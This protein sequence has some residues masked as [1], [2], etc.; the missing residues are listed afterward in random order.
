MKKIC[1]IGAG[2]WGTALAQ[3][4][5]NAGHD[6][7][8]WARETEVVESIKSKHENSLFLKD[9]RLNEM[10]KA[11]HNLNDTEDCDLFFLM[12]PAQHVRATIENFKT[13]LDEKPFVIGSK[14]IELET[15]SLLSDVVEELL[16]HA[17]FGFLSGPTFASEVA[18]GLPCAVTLA[19]NNQTVGKE[20]VEFIGSRT[21]RTYLTTDIIGVQIGG[22]VKN[23]IA[24]ACG[25][26]EGRKMGESARCALIT[27][28]LAEMAR[29]AKGMGAN[30]ETLMGMCGVGDLML[31]CSSMQSRNFSFGY[32]LGEGKTVEEVLGE[33]IAVTEGFHT[34]KALRT[35]AKN[36]AIDMPI[37]RA[38]YDFISENI[39]LEDIFEK[40]LDRPLRLESI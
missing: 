19:M 38:V 37:S 12:T 30:K 22:S 14:G 6:V 27:R 36:N 8:I 9:V 4:L 10:I 29:L 17:T 2:A 7:L 28:G 31:T 33:R 20:I 25:V 26:V 18:R 3:N 16:P 1:V 39:E 40:L 15:G 21:L 11:T 5:A 24:I 13:I 23:V 35:M 32:A 34:A